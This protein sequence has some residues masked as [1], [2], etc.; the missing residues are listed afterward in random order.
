M[1][2]S[3]YLRWHEL[4]KR[5]FSYESTDHEMGGHSKIPKKTGNENNFCKKKFDFFLQRWQK[6]THHSVPVLKSQF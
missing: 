5:S 2:I 1:L 6:A 3:N 4:E